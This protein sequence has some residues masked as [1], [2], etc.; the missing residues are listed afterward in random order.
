[1]LRQRILTAIVL[2]LIVAAAVTAPTPWPMLALLGLMIGCALWE[3]LRLVIDSA[4]V[5][6]GGAVLAGTTSFPLRRE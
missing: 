6:W 3:W 4:A 2:L 1:M 5:R